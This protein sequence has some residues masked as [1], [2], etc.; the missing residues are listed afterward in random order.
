MEVSTSEMFPVNLSYK[1]GVKSLYTSFVVSYLPELPHYL[2]TGIGVGSIIPLSESFYFNP[3]LLTQNRLISENSFMYSLALNVGYKLTDQL[4][5]TAGP[6]IAWNHSSNTNE[7]FKENFAIRKWALDDHNNLFV[8]VRIG[9][10]YVFTDF[11]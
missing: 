6:S 4:H 2:A 7:L 10:R 8:G 3:E 9:I 11:D 1:I 5:L